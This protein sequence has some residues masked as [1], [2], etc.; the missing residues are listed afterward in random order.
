VVEDKTGEPLIALR[1]R[2]N[3][4]DSVLVEA[5]PP[6]VLNEYGIVLMYNARNDGNHH[7]SSLGRDAYSAGQALF[8][9][10]DPRI[11]IERLDEPFLRPELPYERSGQYDSGSTFIEGLVRFHGRWFL[12]YGCADSMV[13][14]VTA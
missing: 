13:D 2:E 6:A 14:V 9:P 8:D 5:G 12:Y 1:P 4:F 7:T 3:M 11:L 10:R